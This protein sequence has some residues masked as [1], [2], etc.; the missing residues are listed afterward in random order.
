MRHVS[1]LR[2]P[3]GK[4]S[5]DAL[6]SEILAQNEV[7]ASRYAEPYAGGCGLALLKL[8]DGTFDSIA[9]NDIDYQMWCFWNLALR[10]PRKLANLIRNC[11]VSVPTWIHSRYVHDNPN[12]FGKDEVGFA[13]FFLNRTSV[14]GVVKSGGMI[15]GQKQDGK[16]KIDCR[17]N[18]DGLIKRIETIARVRKKIS[19]TRLDAI[20]FI[21]END[22]SDTFFMIDPPY[23]EKGSTLY[24]SFYRRQDH[25]DL[26]TAISNLGSSWMLTYDN[27]DFIR[28][29]YCNYFQIPFDLRYSLNRKRMGREVCILHESMKLDSEQKDFGT[30]K[31]SA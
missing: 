5:I 4:A 29:L 15:G 8:L 6:L 3:G 31:V 27:C 19:L 11:N 25:R 12:E 2:Y 28:R 21:A 17:F 1:P 9:I 24:T 13:T 10:R 26:E 22:D 23:F 16:Y 20:Q 18:K 14:S 30:I 7:K